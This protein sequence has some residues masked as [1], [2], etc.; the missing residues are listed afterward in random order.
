MLPVRMIK[1]KITYWRSTMNEGKG[2]SQAHF[3]RKVFIGRSYVSKLEK[4]VAEP[5]AA[6]MFR[7]ARYFKQSIEAVFQFAD[8]PQIKAQV[9]LPTSQIT[10]FTPVPAKPVCSSPATS[11]V[12]PAGVKPTSDKTLKGTKCN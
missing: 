7:A 6:L 2:V 9:S 5:S 11:P 3:A 10:E 8:D 12:C 4:G 1:N